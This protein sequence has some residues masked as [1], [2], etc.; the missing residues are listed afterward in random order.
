M[1]TVTEQSIPPLLSIAD[2]IFSLA[3]SVAVVKQKMNDVIIL[4]ILDKQVEAGK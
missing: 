2:P 3:H 1:S 4:P